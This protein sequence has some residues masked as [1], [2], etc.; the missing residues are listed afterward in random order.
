MGGRGN[1]RFVRRTPSKDAVVVGHGSYSNSLINHPDSLGGNPEKHVGHV[2]VKAP[3][4]HTVCDGEWFSS[5]IFV[6]LCA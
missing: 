4:G 2:Q 3:T 1:C 5:I 6:L